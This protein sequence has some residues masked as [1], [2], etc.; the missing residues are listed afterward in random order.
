MFTVLYETVFPVVDKFFAYFS[1]IAMLPFQMV[2]DF[3]FGSNLSMPYIVA[4]GFTGAEFVFRSNLTPDP[5][6]IVAKLATSGLGQLLG[7]SE[8]PFFLALLVMFAECFIAI[9]IG[10]FVVRIITGL[11]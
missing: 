4:H 3:L 11:M 10:R 8:L 7:V 2:I 6:A 5:F 1:T 9:L